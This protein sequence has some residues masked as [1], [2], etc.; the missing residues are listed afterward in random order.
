MD[1]YAIKFKGYLR[2]LAGHRP[3]PGGGSTLAAAA[4]IG[5]SLI[6]KSLQYSTLPNKKKFHES[7][8]KI[9]K[10]RNRVLPL[11]DLD[12]R[13]FTQLL[14]ARSQ[15]PTRRKLL[16]KSEKIMIEIGNASKA[17]LALTKVVEFDVKKCIISDFLIGRA[18]L[19]LALKGV[20]VNLEANVH[21]FH[22]K[23]NYI[24]IFKT[25]LRQWQKF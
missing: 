2:D 9:E 10:I 8:R 20:V 15:G 16:I 22:K 4:C 24:V 14:H 7:I 13:I 12:G 17:L 11:I 19:L 3:S 5:A 25:K 21:L 18:Y 6:E 1:N 23:S